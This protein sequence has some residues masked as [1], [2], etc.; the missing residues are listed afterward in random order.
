MICFR[1]LDSI[2]PSEPL[3]AA[4][5][6]LKAGRSASDVFCP[7][8]ESFRKVPKAPF[9]YWVSGQVL[10]RFEALESFEMEENR[11]ARLGINTTDDFR[12]LRLRWETPG[13][14]LGSRWWSL[15]KGGG[16]AP[17]YNPSSLVIDWEDSGKRLKSLIETQGDSPSRNVR[18][19]SLYGRA[20]LTYSSRTQKGLSFQPLPKGSLFTVKGPGLFFSDQNEMNALFAVLNSRPFRELVSL[21]MAFGSY[22]VG[23]IQRTPVPILDSESSRRLGS[24]AKRAWALKYFIDGSELTSAAAIAPA[25]LRVQGENLVDRASAWS[26]QLAAC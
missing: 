2:D 13:A 23:V 14:S 17:F 12:F 24:L 4:V 8:P 21:Q 25:L 5:D 16:F 26:R 18:S 1:L 10:D 3:A 20:G 15:F 6:A 19:E 9:A 22:E 11:Q 7:D